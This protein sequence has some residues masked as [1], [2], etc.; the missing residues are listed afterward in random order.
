MFL[1]VY[2]QFLWSFIALLTTLIVFLKI[3]LM[4]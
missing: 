2:N 1:Y 4:W 3:I